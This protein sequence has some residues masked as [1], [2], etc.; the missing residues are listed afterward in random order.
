MLSADF[1]V[2]YLRP[3]INFIVIV[4][5]IVIVN[6]KNSSIHHNYD[7]L[8]IIHLINYQITF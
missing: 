3:W 2:L 6:P 8:I 1:F 5:A 4:I 7:F